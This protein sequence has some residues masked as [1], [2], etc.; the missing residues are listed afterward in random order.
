VQAI[1][2]DIG[3]NISELPA[4]ALRFC[5]TPTAVSTVIPGMRNLRHVASNVAASNAGPL[6]AD[7]LA[8]LHPHRWVRNFWL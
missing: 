4:L 2:H 6:P 1:V 5:L 7:V 3:I 8:K